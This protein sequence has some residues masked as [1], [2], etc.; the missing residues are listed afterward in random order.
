MEGIQGQITRKLEFLE[1][2]QQGKSYAR[3]ERS[4]NVRSRSRTVTSIDAPPHE[5]LPKFSPNEMRRS[6]NLPVSLD[7]PLCPTESDALLQEMS[8]TAAKDIRESI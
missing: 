3:A 2:M 1:L 6:S 7:D 5:L 8:N 4:V